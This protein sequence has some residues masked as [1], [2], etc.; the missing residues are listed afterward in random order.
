M[1]AR[2]STCRPRMTCALQRLRMPGVSSAKLLPQTPETL[3]RDTVMANEI[4]RE[5]EEREV[6]KLGEIS[7][8]QSPTLAKPAG[9][10]VDCP[11]EAGCTKHTAPS[12]AIY[13][14]ME[15]SYENFP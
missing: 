10:G 12:H 13:L 9:S 4:A 1:R 6:V 2:G 14:V 11:A 15:W 8:W 3:H 5:R 7:I